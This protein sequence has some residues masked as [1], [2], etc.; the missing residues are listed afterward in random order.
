MLL[1]GK[2]GTLT[3]ALDLLVRR[4]QKPAGAGVAALTVAGAATTAGAA[5]TAGAL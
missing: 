1:L 5:A 2:S 3:R 4:G